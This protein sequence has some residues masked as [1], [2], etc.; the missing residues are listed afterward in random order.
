MITEIICTFM[1]NEGMSIQNTVM[2]KYNE[3]AFIVI[4]KLLHHSIQNVKNE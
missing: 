4:K 2:R 1:K 3:F